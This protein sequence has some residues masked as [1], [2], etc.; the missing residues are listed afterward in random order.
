[1]VGIE[2][3][4]TRLEQ[5][6]SDPDQILGP[7]ERTSLEDMIVSF[8]ANG[9]YVNFLEDSTGS[10]EVGKAADITVLDRNLFEIPETEI[11]E[12]R[13]LLTFFEGKEVF[14]HAEF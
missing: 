13:V 2:Q 5:G 14:R 9:A 8:T 11:S 7:G 6:V 10:L 4:V 1:V 12:A 3:G